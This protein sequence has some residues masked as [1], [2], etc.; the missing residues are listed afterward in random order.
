MTR[1]AR[2]AGSPA[3]AAQVDLSGEDKQTQSK[4]NHSSVLQGGSAIRSRV[5][6]KGTGSSLLLTL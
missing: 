6:R 4:L 5:V 2:Q 3:D 1:G